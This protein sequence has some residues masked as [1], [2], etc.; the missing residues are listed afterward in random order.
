MGTKLNKSYAFFQR[1][2]KGEQFP[3][4]LWG[5]QNSDIK[6]QQGHY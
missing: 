2:Q 5:H 1:T 6:T 4:L 3:I